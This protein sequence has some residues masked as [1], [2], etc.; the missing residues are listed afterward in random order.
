MWLLNLRVVLISID[1]S[2]EYV[3][4]Q[5]VKYHFT[6]DV[7]VLPKVPHQNSKGSTS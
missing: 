6:G 2:G 7:H 5:L 3:N 1:E 4:L